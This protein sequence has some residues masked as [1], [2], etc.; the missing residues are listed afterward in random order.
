MAWH[1]ASQ[2]DA[3]RASRSP[4]STPAP[5]ACSVDRTREG[6]SEDWALR[7]HYE[8]M[9]EFGDFASILREDRDRPVEEQNPGSA[10][11][12]AAAAPIG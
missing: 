9:P 5:T 6:T 2:A 10:S 3:V 7:L 11:L 12:L 4:S 8:P 1:G